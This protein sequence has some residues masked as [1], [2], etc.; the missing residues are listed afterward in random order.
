MYLTGGK[1]VMKKGIKRNIVSLLCMVVI[2]IPN[3]T[4]A[5]VNA[6]SRNVRSTETE[7]AIIGTVRERVAASFNLSDGDYLLTGKNLTVNG[8]EKE[9]GDM[10]NKPGDYKI[11]ETVSGTV[12]EQDV[13]LYKIGDANLDGNPCTTDDLKI[14]SE[15][16]KQYGIIETLSSA[17][18]YAADLNNDNIVDCTDLLLME[19]IVRK[20]I[21]LDEVLQK[22]YP[23]ALSFNYLGGDEV[24]PVLGYYGPYKNTYVDTVSDE[25]FQLLK[26]SGVNV[27][28]A[29]VN[30]MGSN[31]N[32]TA[33][34]LI[35]L[36]DKYQIGYYMKDWS[37]NQE[38]LGKQ[39]TTLTDKEVAE[40]ISRY[41]F[42]GNYLGATLMD[43]PW[44]N[45]NAMK[46]DGTEK[47]PADETYRLCYYDDCASQINKFANLDAYMTLLPST[48]W[49]DTEWKTAFPEYLKD[50]ITTAS[51]KVLCYDEYPYI[52]AN[53][54]VKNAVKY[55]RS[56]D[57]VRY[58][59]Q[60]AQVPFWGYVQ[61][62]TWNQGVTVSD[63]E[64]CWNVN[65]LLA[66]GAKGIGWY[67]VV[68]PYSYSVDTDGNR[69]YES[70]ALI[71]ANGQ[72]T[73]VYN[74]AQKMNTFISSVDEVLMKAN[75]KGVIVT[76]GYAKKNMSSCDY[77]EITVAD[78][79]LLKNVQTD[80]TTYGAII[81]CF[82]YGDMEAFYVVNNNVEAS[83]HVSLLFDGRFQYRCLQGTT[84]K[85]ETGESVSLMIPAGEAVLV[86]IEDK[87]GCVIPYT[88]TEYQMLNG[89]LPSKNGYVFAGW[90]TKE[91]CGED[92]VMLEVPSTG[93][94]YAKFV[95]ESILTVKMQVQFGTNLD[96]QSTKVRLITTV[97][98]LDYAEVGF[99]ICAKGKTMSI[100]TKTV[101]ESLVG[102]TDTLQN[103]YTADVFAS[104]SKYFMTCN[105]TDIPRV[106][107][108]EIITVTPKWKTLDGVV[109][110]GISRSFCVKD[111]FQGSYGSGYELYMDA[112]TYQNDMT[113][114]QYGVGCSGLV[115]VVTDEKFG[116]VYGLNVNSPEKST[117]TNDYL[118]RLK[119]TGTIN[120]K[121]LFFYI[122]NPTNASVPINI[123][124]L[125]TDG[126]NY[127]NLLAWKYLQPGWNRIEISKDVVLGQLLN[128]II[129]E[130]GKMLQG[131]W[132]ITGLYA[133][134]DNLI[135]YKVGEVTGKMD[136]VPN[137]DQL[138]MPKD[139]YYMDDIR[140][141]KTCYDE[142]PSHAKQSI[143]Q[144]VADKLLVCLEKTEGYGFMI[145][146]KTDKAYMQIGQYG[147]GCQGELTVGTDV[148]Y[149]PV[150]KMNITGPKAKEGIYLFTVNTTLV[151][152]AKQVIFYLYNPTNISI[153]MN[154]NTVNSGGSNW[155]NLVSWK[156]IHPGWNQI[157][158]SSDT[159]FEQLIEGVF[160]GTTE[161]DMTGMWMTSSFYTVSDSTN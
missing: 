157:T 7:D 15:Y 120:A 8:E 139:G 37:L 78:T 28:T 49:T 99:D 69:D 104:A 92:N 126:S 141:A 5:T 34:Q 118:F 53:T 133:F 55:M 79:K 87:A 13:S 98:T 89:S 51:L 35:E 75:S 103:S 47:I 64:I 138:I 10:L 136:K 148:E 71:G 44:P 95:D 56:L 140:W 123:N 84:D 90:Y 100:V 117:G 107:F 158:L 80:D 18:E 109:V 66:F 110:T 52:N 146:A 72:K 29:A 124:T 48:F 106:D 31:I 150:L 155:R 116:K 151:L 38:V 40:L 91:T 20:V 14:L 3:M 156:T 132:K 88:L 4:V 77:S 105:L 26:E 16:L 127:T 25:V 50:A 122:Y 23:P 59:S 65:T 130:A 68:Q 111:M 101:Y 86:V 153:C 33:L 154:F 114:G 46:A 30:D 73:G 137:A 54:G 119:T 128:G 102:Y 134:S 145:R 42:Y 11:R 6:E 97:D 60:N 70:N 76:S 24:M 143:S 61:A 159:G 22:Y 144:T 2:C 27:I 67:P 83:Q 131:Q 93:N 142:L 81:G 74:V 62:G 85:T 121:Y 43:E 36:A 108:N 9:A 1:K 32:Q 63:A 19:D 125:N 41:S 39:G 147:N 12:Y 152:D 129:P 135:S 161:Y 160:C 58:V 45:K 21:S 94:V 96:S 112:K 17:T 115:E 149:G 113:V 57:M 82:D